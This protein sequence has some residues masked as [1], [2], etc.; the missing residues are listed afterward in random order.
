MPE[1]EQNELEL[2]FNKYQDI[3][4]NGIVDDAIK[5]G[6]LYFTLLHGEMTDEDKEQLQNDI[7]LYAVK[8]KGEWHDF[9]IYFTLANNS[10]SIPL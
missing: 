9:V 5:H 8:N 3:L 2:L 7:L 10:I 1:E 4:K 6:Q